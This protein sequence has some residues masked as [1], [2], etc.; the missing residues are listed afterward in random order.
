VKTNPAQRLATVNCQWIFTPSVSFVPSFGVRPIYLAYCSALRQTLCRA[1]HSNPS[2]T[3]ENWRS[4]A[5]WAFLIF[6]T[7]E[8][9]SESPGTEF[10]DYLHKP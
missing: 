4:L 8:N 3:M 1:Y 9:P 6:G 7:A 5:F 10:A 2:K